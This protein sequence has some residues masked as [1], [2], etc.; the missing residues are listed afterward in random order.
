[1]LD[2]GKYYENYEICLE[3]ALLQT[4]KIIKEN[5]INGNKTE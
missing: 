3:T 4:L 2:D 1:M 5:N